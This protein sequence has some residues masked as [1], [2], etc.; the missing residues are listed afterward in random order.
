MT[1][2]VSPVYCM[3]SPPS[4]RTLE[5]ET[6]TPTKIIYLKQECFSVKRVVPIQL[7]GG[8]ILINGMQW[9]HCDSHCEQTDRQTDISENMTFPQNAYAGGN[10]M[11]KINEQSPY[12]ILLKPPFSHPHQNRL[13][14]LV[15]QT[16]HHQS[17]FIVFCFEFQ[18]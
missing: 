4:C 6:R 9:S 1:Q 13:C 10:E 16:S 11:S 7:R 15:Q 8:A 18:K 2:K 3:H 12:R 14:W 5:P 17:W